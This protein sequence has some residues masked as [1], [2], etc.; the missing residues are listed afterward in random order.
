MPFGM[1]SGIGQMRSVLDGVGDRRRE[2]VSFGGKCVT[3]HCN[4]RGLCGIVIFLRGGNA[5]FEIYC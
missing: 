4:Q 5:A 2:R 3:S 1:V